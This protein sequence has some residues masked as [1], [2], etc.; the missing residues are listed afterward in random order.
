MSEVLVVYATRMGSTREIAEEIGHQLERR[1]LT[2][3]VCST[4]EAAAPTGHDAVVVGSPVYLRRWD[5]SA[6]AYLRR[7]ATSLGERRTWLFQSGPCGPREEVSA[8][9]TPRSVTRFCTRTGIAAPVTFGG[10]LDPARATS[11]LSAKVT[12]GPLSGD[13]R[14]WAEIRAWADGLA[15]RLLA[16]RVPADRSGSR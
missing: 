12:R 4:A 16:D 1:G 5:A 8:E 11:W 3:E 10:N 7:H 2:A 9:P 6:L 14:D 15:D 13:F